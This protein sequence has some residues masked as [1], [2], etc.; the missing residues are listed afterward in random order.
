M[1]IGDCVMQ[2][3]HQD[4]RLVAP[5]TALAG[6]CSRACAGGCDVRDAPARPRDPP[7]SLPP[8]TQHVVLLAPDHLTL[9][10]ASPCPAASARSPWYL[11]PL[12]LPAVTPGAEM[13]LTGDE[14]GRLC[15][16]SL[17][18]GQLLASVQAHNGR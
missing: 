3:A 18:G 10:P 6:G 8:S 2:L 5:L 7:P 4:K 14:A 1:D 12:P 16:W 9:H 15:A 11:P 17:R 13:C